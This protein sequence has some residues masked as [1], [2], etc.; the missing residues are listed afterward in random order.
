M[1]NEPIILK[2]REKGEDYEKEINRQELFNI[3]DSIRKGFSDDNAISTAFCESIPDVVTIFINKD[4][5]AEI[6]TP[7][8]FFECEERKKA[9]DIIRYH[10]V[11]WSIIDRYTKI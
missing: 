6:D 4:R 5:N 2:W 7:F 8:I 3:M 9:L 1:K 10:K 11:I